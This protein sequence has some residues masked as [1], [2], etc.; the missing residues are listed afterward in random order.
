MSRCLSRIHDAISLS[1]VGAQEH[2]KLKLICYYQMVTEPSTVF[3]RSEAAATNMFMPVVGEATIRERLITHSRRRSTILF[4]NTKL[5][6]STL[7]LYRVSS[8]IF[9]RTLQFKNSIKTY[10]LH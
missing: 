10:F 1:V 6:T 7:Y 3:A 9:H 2:S 4:I 8:D 5:S